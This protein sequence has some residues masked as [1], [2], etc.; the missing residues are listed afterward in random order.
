MDV[1]IFF[2]LLLINSVFLSSY[3][4][5]SFNIPID[6]PFE[7]IPNITLSFPMDYLVGITLHNKKGQIIDSYGKRGSNIIYIPK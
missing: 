2:I 6:K 1:K 3:F 5:Y 4:I 7:T